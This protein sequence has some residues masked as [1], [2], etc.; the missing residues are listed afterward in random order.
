MNTR[1]HCKEKGPIAI[2]WRIKL[3]TKKNLVTKGKQNRKEKIVYRIR[4]TNIGKTNKETEDTD[5]EENKKYYRQEWS[6]KMLVK[7]NI[8]ILQMEAPMGKIC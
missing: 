4:K 8:R 2:D 3:A 6:K 1:F 5:R 7:T